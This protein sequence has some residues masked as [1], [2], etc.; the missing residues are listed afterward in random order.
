MPADT[1]ARLIA[2]VK[3][4]RGDR[5]L[6][7]PS[8]LVGL[9]SEDVAA[10]DRFA[11]LMRSASAEDLDGLEDLD[12]EFGWLVVGAADE[13]DLLPDDPRL[14]LPKV[15]VDGLPGG[16]LL[17]ALTSACILN[18][19]RT[20]RDIAAR[21]DVNQLDHNGSTAL[22][23]AV[24]NNHPECAQALLEQG[25]DPNR[26]LKDGRTPL[27]RAASNACSRSLFDMLVRAGGNLEHRDDK[28]RSVRDVLHEFG[29]G[30]WAKR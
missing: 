23:Y 12:E 25:A 4:I 22:S 24:G 27:H 21:I 19:V 10:A 28:G 13:L 11:E 2:F 8:D 15:A 30:A 3:S 6:E 5:T 20:V 18:D 29:R 1:R 26:V 9:L 14:F 7:D 16:A 17:Q